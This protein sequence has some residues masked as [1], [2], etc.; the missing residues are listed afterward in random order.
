MKYLILTLIVLILGMIPSSV[1]AQETR[2]GDLIKASGPSV[3]YLG[4]DGKRY[5]FPNEKIFYTWYE[6]FDSVVEISDEELASYL[7]GGLIAYKPG[8]RLVKI[9]SDPKVYAVSAEYQDNDVFKSQ[10]TVL[11]WI[12]NE[13]IANEIYGN[14]WSVR[15]D[16]LPDSL[17][18]AYEIGK[19]IEDSWFN[20]GNFSIH[21]LY[22]LKAPEKQDCPDCV[23]NVYR[24]YYTKIISALYNDGAIFWRTYPN[25][26]QIYGINI[27]G[28]PEIDITGLSL[29]YT[30]TGAP[31]EKSDV[32]VM[33]SG[34]YYGDNYGNAIY[35]T[36]GTSTASTSTTDIN[37]FRIMDFDQAIRNVTL[38]MKNFYVQPNT[39]HQFIVTE[40]RG[41]TPEGEVV[42]QNVYVP[43]D[44][45]WVPGE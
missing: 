19:D 4:L 39:S 24:S 26:N 36:F 44:I 35:P 9:Q 28:D 31:L 34:R 22:G 11:R 40:I 13:T 29:E 15:V 37:F 3:Y 10:K 32:Q 38:V 33:N 16:D 21:D 30:Y 1:L 7:I 12:K 5:V 6:D 45:I 41:V 20:T 14:D 8:S 23:F 43:L 27:E 42:K 2:A 18:F 25:S 17:F